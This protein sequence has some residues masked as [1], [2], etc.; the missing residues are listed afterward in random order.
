MGDKPKPTLKKLLE[1]FRC[2]GLVGI[3]LID[4]SNSCRTFFPRLE[5][6]FRENGL[7]GCD[8]HKPSVRRRLLENAIRELIGKPTS[9]GAVI[10]RYEFAKTAS[11][12]DWKVVVRSKG[13]REIEV[14]VRE[15]LESVE[16]DEQKREKH[17]PEEEI[18]RVCTE[19]P[20]NGSVLQELS[21]IFESATSLTDASESVS[22]EALELLKYFDK[23]FD[24]DSDLDQND[25]SKAEL[26][27]E[28]YS[29]AAGK[30]LVDFA[31]RQGNEPNRFTDVLSYRAEALEAF[32]CQSRQPKQ[33]NVLEIDVDEADLNAIHYFHH[34]F[35]GKIQASD[36]VRSKVQ[37]LIKAHGPEFA[38][39][40]VDFVSKKI[41]SSQSNYQPKSFSGI[42]RSQNEALDEW[43]KGKRR[44]QKEQREARKL[45]AVK[46][47][48]AR[49]DHEKFY[50]NSYYEYVNELVGSLGDEYPE[51]FNEFRSWQA[52]RRR[53][54]EKSEGNIRDVLLR[55]FDSEGQSILRLMR[56]FKNDP[57]VHIPDFWEWDS[58]RNPNPFV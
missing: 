34:K 9:S 6:F 15:S 29:L 44:K 49:L 20:H 37:S 2:A 52:D 4:R 40:L 54:E 56:F 25:A 32:K 10:R 48:N 33:K 16:Q 51:R 30:F 19:A 31:H 45:A 17:Q 50:R 24:L 12:K 8:Y 53:E 5:R 14:E 7:I 42:L 11:E 41:G 27:I 28:R 13:S 21:E 36:K 18:A 38:I 39:F 22:A 26:F 23:V 55:V 3:Y 46:H 35:G 43:E 57:D 58:T 47:E 1:E